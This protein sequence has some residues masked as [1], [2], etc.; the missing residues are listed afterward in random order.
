MKK[1]LLEKNYHSLEEDYDEAKEKHI[2]K[3]KYAII[4]NFKLQQ[5]RETLWIFTLSENF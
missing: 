3:M 2:Q 5:S 4:S 1:L